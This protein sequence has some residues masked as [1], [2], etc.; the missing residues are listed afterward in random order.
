MPAEINACKAE[1]GVF[2]IIS[3]NIIEYDT[4]YLFIDNGSERPSTL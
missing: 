3:E 1:N 2:L 4:E